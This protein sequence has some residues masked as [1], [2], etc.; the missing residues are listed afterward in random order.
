MSHTEAMSCKLPLLDGEDTSE[1]RLMTT[2][3]ELESAEILQNFSKGN[4]A[5]FDDM[6]CAAWGL[7]LRCYTGQDNVSFYFE[8]DNADDLVSKSAVPRDR[9]STFRMAFH[10]QET[11]SMCV[12]RAKDGYGESERGGPSLVSTVSD[13]RSLPSSYYQNT[14]VRVEDATCKRMQDVA[15]QKVF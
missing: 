2:A 9:Q 8:Q 5:S 7:L 15:V 3:L 12:A 4:V 1:P 11:L 14:H 6:I 13:S 10:E